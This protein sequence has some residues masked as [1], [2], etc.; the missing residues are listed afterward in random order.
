MSSREGV[1]GSKEERSEAM[2]PSR[3][4]IGLS[5]EPLSIQTVYGSALSPS[6]GAVAL[7]VGV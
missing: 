4:L 1:G 5:S 6:C 7:F 2:E 3:D